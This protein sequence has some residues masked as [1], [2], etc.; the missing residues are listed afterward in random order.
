LPKGHKKIKLVIRVFKKLLAQESE[1]ADGR[2]LPKQQEESPS[3]IGQ[4]AG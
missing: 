1:L 2:L 3:S 4:G